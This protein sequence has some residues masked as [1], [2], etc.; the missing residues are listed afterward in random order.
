VRI[1]YAGSPDIAVPALEFLA[2]HYDVAAVLTSP[3]KPAGRKRILKPCPVAVA[4]QALDL[5]VFNPEKLDPDFRESVKALKPDLLVV[6]AYGKIFRQVFLDIFPMGGINMHPSLLPLHRGPS[7]IPAAIAA[8]DSYTGISIQELALAM[9]SGDIL[10]QHTLELTGC[11]T[12]AS[13]SDDVAL[14]SGK[15]FDRV[16]TEM[17]EKKSVAVP[18]NHDKA[19]YCTLINKE[20]GKIDWKQP[21]ELID[22]R[23]RAF[24]PWPGGV[25]SWKNQPLKIISAALYEPVETYS[26]VLPGAVTGVDKKYGI[27]VQTGDG[28]LALKELQLPS[29]KAVDFKS[30]MNGNR[31]ILTACLGENNE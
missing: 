27:L 30:F 10:L 13:L 24:T 9:D 20:D 18:Q 6:F 28:L 17:D 3:D 11:E 16:L 15:L 5:P 22:R 4:A 19:T 25:T 31:D 14:L 2:S 7:P 8:G 12:T 29:K 1:I 21:A 23:L 26:P